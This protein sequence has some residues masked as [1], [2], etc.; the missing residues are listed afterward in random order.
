M[1]QSRKFTT[2]KSR[3]IRLT[4]LDTCGAVV[5]GLRS[6]IVHLGGFTKVES[7]LDVQE[8][9]A[10]E[11]PDAWG[12]FCVNERDKPKI[13]GADVSA[14]FC[15]V[16][17]DTHELAAGARLLTAGAADTF[18]TTGDSVGYA[19][20]EDTVPGDFM[21]E[22]W[23]KVG[24][25]V[26][27]AGSPVWLYTRWPW[28]TNTVPGDL[29]LE[30]GTATFP[31]AGRANPAGAVLPDDVYEANL[32]A[33]A[34]GEVILQRLVVVQPPEATNGAVELEEPED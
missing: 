2:V 14:E 24:G 13:K 1:V 8:G 32:P 33:H 11:L 27:V 4:R 31:L 6:T 28:L 18:A 20:G 26:C 17:P 5:F 9:E 7:A 16:D 15:A 25:G 34:V 19:I 23:T 30:R 10:F 22:T 21:L 29:T 3:A 12:D